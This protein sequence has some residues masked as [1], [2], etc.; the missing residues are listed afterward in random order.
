MDRR[1]GGPFET[2]K[3][4]A[5]PPWRQNFERAWPGGKRREVF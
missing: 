3:V 5:M 2:A 1:D 4:E